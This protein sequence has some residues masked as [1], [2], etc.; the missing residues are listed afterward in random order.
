MSVRLD[1]HSETLKVVGASNTTKDNV[2]EL[3]FGTERIKA[4]LLD[5]LGQ[6]LEHHVAS[7]ALGVALIIHLHATALVNFIVI[8][9]HRMAALFQLELSQMDNL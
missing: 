2:S 4:R 8:D 6:Q 5:Q 9:Q 3:L 1:N 7:G